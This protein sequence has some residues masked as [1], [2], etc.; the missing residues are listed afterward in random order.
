[1]VEIYC[2]LETT[3]TDRARRLHARGKRMGGGQAKQ[4]DSVVTL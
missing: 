3:D 4:V 2:S 1:M